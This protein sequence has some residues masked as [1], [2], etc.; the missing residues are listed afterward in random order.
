MSVFHLIPNQLGSL[1]HALPLVVPCH[2]L[3]KK[4]MVPGPEVQTCNPALGRGHQGHQELHSDSG[5]FKKA[6]CVIGCSFLGARF[7]TLGRLWF[8]HPNYTTEG[9]FHC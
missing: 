9:H 2:M 1:W 4:A 3:H 7:F 8:V 6:A 5:Y